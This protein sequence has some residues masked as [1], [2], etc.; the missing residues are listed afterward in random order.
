MSL[1]E[2]QDTNGVNSEEN[3]DVK[4][5]DGKSKLVAEAKQVDEVILEKSMK[6]KYIHGCIKLP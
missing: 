4:A 2:L 5:K 1:I 6:K 3:E